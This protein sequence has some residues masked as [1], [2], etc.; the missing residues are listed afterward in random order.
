EINGVLDII[1]VGLTGPE[2]PVLIP[3]VDAWRMNGT[4]TWANGSAM[5]ENFLLST[6]DGTDYVPITV[7]ENGTFATYVESGDYIVVVAPLLN[8]DA[9]TESLRMPITIGADSSVRTDLSLSLVEAVEVSLS[10]MEAGTESELVGKKVVLVSHDG[11]GNITMNPSDADGNATQ[12]LMPGTWSL[13]M[14]ESAAQRYWTIDTSD[15]PVLI[16][17][18]TSLGVVYAELE[19][20][21]GGK[22][23]W[24]TDEDDIA[25]GNEGV[26]GAEVTIQ[27]GSIDTV[28][29]T[30]ADGVWRI[31]VPI[32]ENYA[33][34]VAKDGFGVVSYDDNN[35]GTYI[36]DNEPVSQD[37]EMSAAEVTVTGSITDVLDASRLDG[38]SI[39]LYG[40]S[41]NQQDSVEVVGTYDAETL[42]FTAIVEPGQWVVVVYEDD[43]PFNGGGVA[44]GLLD[45]EVQNGGTIELVMSKGGWVDVSTEFTSFNLQTF[46]A[47]TDD[48]SSPVSEVVDV[49]VD[50]GDGRVWTLPLE[51]DG[52]L[53]VLLPAESSTF[54]S[55]FSTVQRDLVMNYTAGISIDN[56]DEG[57]TALMLS[58]NRKT[59]SDVS[60]TVDSVVGGTVLGDEN[61]DLLATV[62][63]SD[64]ANYTTIE[65]DVLAQY[66]GTE[67]SDPFE[68][69][70][71]VTVSPDQDDWSV[72]FY[73]G[74]DWVSTSNVQLGI[75]DVAE[76]ATLDATLRARIVL[77]SVE[78]AWWLENGHDVNIRFS[79]DSGDMTEVSINVEIP[80]TYGFNTTD[81]SSTIGVAPGASTTATMTLNN[82]GNGDD[83]FTYE[84]LDNLPEGWTISP[85]NGVTTIAKDN[86]RDLAFAVTSA[87]TFDDGQVTVTVR[88]TSEDGV[89]QEDVE[90]TVE[91]ARIALSWDEDLS[92]SRSNGFADVDPN[93]VVIVIK[94][95]GLRPAQQ[96]TVYL[97]SNGM[98]EMN[99]TLSVPAEGSTD[100]EFD[101]PK[102]SQGIT[103]YDVRTE[104]L[105][106]DLNYTT[107]Q[108]DGDFGIEYLVQGS[109]DS[110]NSIVIIA[111]IALIFI[112]LYF[113]F[114][115]SARAR[116]S[117]SRF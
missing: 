18:N 65:F 102:A 60:L 29:T 68:V 3:I 32:L 75:G 61:R 54:N 38:A 55:E 74:T 89:T 95:T 103:R 100:F 114:K 28:V 41:E 46:N 47:G 71:S 115:A 111:I 80:Q 16:D 73:N 94:N 66:E 64:T 85:M 24:D 108:V 70:G 25:D 22:A 21:I 30:D 48:A 69:T 34:T 62:N 43:A 40:T 45:A 20:E 7:D 35:S 14:N 10:L 87:S 31:Y 51:S 17:A 90:I 112:I 58:Y 1:P 110:S 26:E 99:M 2:E 86:M 33:V 91:S 116:G 104:V 53:E 5:V 59:N 56:G 44:V 84:V 117:G 88:I 23:Y 97:D 57:R 77:P 63:S 101:L 4:I 50:L 39:T 96:V 98:A 67:I 13:Y 107:S 109:D 19:V 93:K 6:P 106:D 27:G 49:E 36:V 92:T 81:V 11:F 76:N 78:T 79:A 52:T 113:G 37:I 105:G 9:V 83:S 42:S 72:Q 82:N 15:A 8:G 12:L